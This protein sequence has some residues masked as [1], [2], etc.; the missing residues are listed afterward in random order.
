MI[1]LIARYVKND[2]TVLNVSA[3]IILEKRANNMLYFGIFVS[4]NRGTFIFDHS[5]SHPQ[6]FLSHFK[7]FRGI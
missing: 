5:T 4:D 3:T 1:S 2:T 6:I 7:D